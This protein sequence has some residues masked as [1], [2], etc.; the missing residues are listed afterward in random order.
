MYDGLLPKSSNDH[1]IPRMTWWAHRG[2]KEWVAYRLPKPATVSESDVYWYDDTGRGQCRVPASWR[3]LYREG[4]DWKEVKLTGGAKYGTAKDAFNKVTFEPV[5]AT[6]FRLE[7]Q[8]QRG[9]SGGILEWRL[10][11]KKAEKK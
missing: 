10:G 4:K 5:T 7:V 1:S 11:P 9:V 8:L 6:E 3:L 2:S